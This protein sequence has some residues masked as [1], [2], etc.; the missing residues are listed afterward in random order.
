VMVNIDPA[1]TES[2]PA[3]LKAIVHERDSRLG[4]YGSTVQP[5]RVAVGDTV[6]VEG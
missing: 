1:S 5:G 6:V 3:V 2:N 4:V